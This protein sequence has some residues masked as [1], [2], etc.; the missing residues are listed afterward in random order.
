MQSLS[1]MLERIEEARQKEQGAAR[2]ARE[3]KE[4]AS[5]TLK[6]AQDEDARQQV[7]KAQENAAWQAWQ[8]KLKVQWEVAR[9]AREEE[10]EAEKVAHS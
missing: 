1:Q 6:K 9:R 2:K 7:L 4:K 10:R 8:E 5:A 3:E